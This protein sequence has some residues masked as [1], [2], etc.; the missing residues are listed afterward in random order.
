[1]DN[2]YNYYNPNDHSQNEDQKNVNFQTE[3]DQNGA[4]T[5][6][7]AFQWHPNGDPHKK[8]KKSH[9]NALRT[10]AIVGFAILFGVVSGGVFLTTT[11]IGNRVLGLSDSS[12][13]TAASS[14]KVSN[15]TPL[16]KSSSVVTSD[17]SEVVD[18]VMPSI[19]SITSMSVEEV[20]SFFGGTYEQQTQGAGTGIII[21]KTDTE[22]LIVTNNHVVSGSDT[23]TV[24]FMDESTVEANIKGTDSQYDV[25]VIAVPLENIS[26]ETLDVIA[27][28]TLGDSTSLKVGEPA[29]AIGNAL[30]YGQSVTTGVISALNRSVSMTNEQTGETQDN[31]VKLIQTDA[32]I[33]EGNSGGALVNV[34]GEVIG[35]NSSKLVGDSV[36]GIG[37]AIPISDVSDL[38][39]NLMN[40]ETK[41]K[42]AEEERGLIG[43]TGISVS[44]AFSQQIE[45]PAGVYVTEVAKDGGAA[46]AGMTKGC[47][48]TAINDT[49]VDS[50]D[51]L[52][53]E[54]QYYAKGD[55]VTLKLQIPQTNG[56]YEEQTIEVTLQ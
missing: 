50:M 42:V 47:I 43:I 4:Q 53:E 52:Q 12:I 1:M 26:D 3:N 30:G 51:A 20:R 16:S 18:Q 19:V 14:D 2:Q 28:A 54:L 36:E 11:L 21:G 9:K 39:E 46:K 24:A 55:T 6:G 5:G 44:D 34:N 10:V 48:I 41:T 35:I 40:R 15:G 23:L 27:V 32:A 7:G 22:L 49:T 31:G 45:M 38:I 33:N 56:E 8:E 17:V 37:Y 13:S 29:I 25:A